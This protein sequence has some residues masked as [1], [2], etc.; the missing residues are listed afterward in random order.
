MFLDEVDGSLEFQSKDVDQWTKLDVGHWLVSRG[1][2]E[3]RNAFYGK[4]EDNAIEILAN[5]HLL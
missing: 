3:E 2:D 5:I 1:L 4:L